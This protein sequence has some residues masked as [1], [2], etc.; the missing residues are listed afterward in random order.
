M[1]S[2]V[3][4]QCLFTFALILLCADWVNLTA[5]LRESNRGIGG[6]IQIPEMLLQALHPIR[7]S[8]LENLLAGYLLI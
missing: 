3:P 1:K 4:P 6:R 5:Q 2:N 8:A 7:Q